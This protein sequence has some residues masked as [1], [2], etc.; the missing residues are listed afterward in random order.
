MAWWKSL[1]PDFRSSSDVLPAPSYDPPAAGEVDAWVSLRKGGPNGLVAIL[2]L[3][4]WWGLALC[5]DKP[6][7]ARSF[8]ERSVADV[9]HC[10]E[11]MVATPRV[12]KRKRG[13]G[14]SLASKRAKK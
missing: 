3:L 5:D 9:T 13:A 12:G 11:K 8:W 1:Q 7:E 10:I 6:A 4:N 14:A 2:I